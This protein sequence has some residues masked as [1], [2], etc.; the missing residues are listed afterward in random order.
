[1][2][3]ERLGLSVSLRTSQRI[4]RGDVEAADRIVVEDVGETSEGSSRLSP[5]TPD[6]F[7]GEARLE[8]GKEEI[9]RIATILGEA[10][11]TRYLEVGEIKLESR[12]G[13]IVVRSRVYEPEEEYE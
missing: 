9:S 13:E 7:T 1:M 6:G 4:V 3:G 10:A 8:L 2:E 11:R 5:G 12:P